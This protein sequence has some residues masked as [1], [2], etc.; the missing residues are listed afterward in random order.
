MQNKALWLIFFGIA[1]LSGCGKGSSG[2]GGRTATVSLKDGGDFSGAVTR[3]NDGS[4]ITLK[5]T[6]GETRTYP[7]SQV[8]SVQYAAADSTP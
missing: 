5:S 8:S 4:E 7:M 6:S 3:K 1:M 2:D